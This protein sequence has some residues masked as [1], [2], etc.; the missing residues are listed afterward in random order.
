MTKYQ[1]MKELLQFLDVSKVRI[2]HFLSVSV[3]HVINFILKHRFG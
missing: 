1:P 3:A 2:F